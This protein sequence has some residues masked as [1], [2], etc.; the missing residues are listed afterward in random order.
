MIVRQEREALP[1]LFQSPLRVLELGGQ[2]RRGARVMG[3]GKRAMDNK[4]GCCWGSDPG[5]G[6][7][8]G[9]RDGKLSGDV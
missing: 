7:M 6:V 8:E 3:G 5:E 9:E 1:F 4:R 2:K